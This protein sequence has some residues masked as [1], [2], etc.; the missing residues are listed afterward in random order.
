MRMPSVR[1]WTWWIAH[2][3]QCS[4]APRQAARG[5][6][7]GFYPQKRPVQVPRL[8][9]ERI[10]EVRGFCSGQASPNSAWP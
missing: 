4:E 5:G 3:H 1:R 6:I 10:Q 7:I 8:S 2:R 9:I